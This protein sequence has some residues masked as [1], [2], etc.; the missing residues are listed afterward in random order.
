M[1]RIPTV[2]SERGAYHGG[3]AGDS[4]LFGGTAPLAVRMRPRTMDDIVGQSHL[5]GAGSPLRTLAHPD[6]TAGVSLILWGPAGTGKTTL[7][8]VIS[9]SSERHFIELSAVTAGVKDVR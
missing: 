8:N 6:S 2:I 4:G 9:A 3:M 1:I 5:L 7:A